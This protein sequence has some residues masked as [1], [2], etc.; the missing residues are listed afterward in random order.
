MMLV[1]LLLIQPDYGRPQFWRALVAANGVAINL[2]YIACTDVRAGTARLNVNLRKGFDRYRFCP[3][4]PG[5]VDRGHS[6][7]TRLAWRGGSTVARILIDAINTRRAVRRSESGAKSS[8]HRFRV[9]FVTRF[10]CDL[11]S[12][13]VGSCHAVRDGSSQSVRAIAII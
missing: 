3:R 13:S 4:D 10:C 6:H 5:K 12:D 9:A 8:F 11:L 7:E 2:L 1:A